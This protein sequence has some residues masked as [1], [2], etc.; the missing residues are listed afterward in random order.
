MQSYVISLK[1]VKVTA[2]G[3]SCLRLSA[4][5]I[6]TAGYERHGKVKFNRSPGRRNPFTASNPE[7]NTVLD[8]LTWNLNSRDFF[9]F[10]N[11]SY[12]CH[13]ECMT[14]RNENLY[15]DTRN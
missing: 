13:R 9:V 8:H 7:Y 14:T 11:S 12:Y 2:A 1:G 15:V 5:K 6:M 10:T 4:V 3:Y